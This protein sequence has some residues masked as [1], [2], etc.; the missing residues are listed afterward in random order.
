MNGGDWCPIF[1][2]NGS[3]ELSPVSCLGILLCCGLRMFPD[4]RALVVH[5]QKNLFGGVNRLDPTATALRPH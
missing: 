2:K 1:D 4:N 3:L 5:Q